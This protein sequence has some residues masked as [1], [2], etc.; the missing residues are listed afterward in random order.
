MLAHHLYFHF[1]LSLA[2][3]YH[4][5][6]VLGQNQGIGWISVYLLLWALAQSRFQAGTGF[7]FRFWLGL[8]YKIALSLSNWKGL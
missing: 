5:E 7:G 3:C 8:G 4:G 1:M 6:S 2:V